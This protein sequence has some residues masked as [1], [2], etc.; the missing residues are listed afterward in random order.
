MGAPGLGKIAL[1]RATVRPAKSDPGTHCTLLVFCVAGSARLNI[2]FGLEPADRGAKGLERPV[3][4][5][6]PM[7]GGNEP[8]R[9]THD[10]N[11]IGE[12]GQAQAVT[13]LG[14][15]RTLE[16]VEAE[17]ERIEAG[18]VDRQSLGIGKDQEGRGFSVNPPG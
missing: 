16:A 3:D 4:I 17:F 9:R 7:H 12:H 15:A 1:G 6:W 18:W 13:K 5:A 8:A 2:T 11:A 10:V 14:I